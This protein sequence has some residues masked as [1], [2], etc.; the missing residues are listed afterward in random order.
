M[1]KLNLA[2]VTKYVED[3]IGVFHQK[4]IQSLDNLKLN[5]ALIPQHK[6]L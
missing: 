5:N 1:N 6:F 2:D 4:R 3:H